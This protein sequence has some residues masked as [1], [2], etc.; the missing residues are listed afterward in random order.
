MSRHVIGTKD[1]VLSENVPR[2]RSMTM[3]SRELVFKLWKVAGEIL[4]L[5]L[6]K[7][8]RLGGR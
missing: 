8:R 7:A 4:R 1:G 6:K 5:A 3:S 2:A